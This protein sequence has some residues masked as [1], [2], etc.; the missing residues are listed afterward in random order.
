M[1]SSR[2]T[3]RPPL[4]PLH[5]TPV[6][7]TRVWGG[8]RLHDDL[9]KPLPTAAPYGESWEV[10]DTA[11]VANCHLS[12]ST[13]SELLQTYGADLVGTACATAHGVPLLVKFLDAAEW[14]SVQV[15]PNDQQAAALD[16]EPRGKTESWYVVAA[17]P[18]AQMI[19]GVQ[20]GLPADEI[21]DAIA[22]GQLESLLIYQSVQAGDV[23][24]VTPG[25]IHALGPGILIYEIQQSS[26]LTYRL[27]DWGR[28]GLDGQPRALHIEKGLAVVRTEQIPTIQ[29]T[30]DDTAPLVPIVACDYYTTQLHQF[31]DANGLRTTI[32]LDDRFHLLTCIAGAADVIGGN[33]RTPMTVGQSVFVPA[34]L[35][36][37]TIEAADGARVLRSQQP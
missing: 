22:R 11:S 34:A 13:L 33:I 26:D 24:H 10:H 35:E 12:G 6:M 32:A 20:P 3:S 9:H 23:L 4:Y 16:H 36:S 1:A 17:D 2:S 5:L 21:A 7:H 28:L 25:T 8:R 18:G 37:Y 14:L 27:H 31:S 15:H 29:H 30:A 19:F